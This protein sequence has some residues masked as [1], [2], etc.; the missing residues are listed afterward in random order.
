LLWQAIGVWVSLQAV[1]YS[2]GVRAHRRVPVAVAVV[3][4]V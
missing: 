2:A 1:A 3:V 4:V